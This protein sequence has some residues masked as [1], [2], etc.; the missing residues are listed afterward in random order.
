MSLSVALVWFVDKDLNQKFQHL[1]QKRF[2]ATFFVS[3]GGS[4]RNWFFGSK[5]VKKMSIFVVFLLFFV[6]FGLK[7]F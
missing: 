4:G 6:I 3:E 7:M 5:N 1:E 2:L